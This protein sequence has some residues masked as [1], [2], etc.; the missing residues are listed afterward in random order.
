MDDECFLKFGELIIDTA[1]KVDS[2]LDYLETIY[3]CKLIK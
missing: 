1:N 2:L 3:Y